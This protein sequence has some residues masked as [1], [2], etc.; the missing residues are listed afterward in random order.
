MEELDDRVK[1][2]TRGKIVVSIL[3]GSTINALRKKFPYAK[4][5]IRSMPNITGLV[6]KSATTYCS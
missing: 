2:L 4:N 1:E 5:I 6:N 3:A